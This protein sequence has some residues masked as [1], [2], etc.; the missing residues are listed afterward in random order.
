MS[1]KT[2]ADFPRAPLI[3]AWVE[4]VK[5]KDWDAL[6]ETMDTLLVCSEICSC[7]HPA[8]DPDKNLALFSCCPM[9]GA[10]DS[11]KVTFKQ[12]DPLNVDIQEQN[13]GEV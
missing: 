11:V 9:D 7:I 8:Y 4:Y 5:T 6:L 1:P 13:N 12:D 2:I 10:T 3:H